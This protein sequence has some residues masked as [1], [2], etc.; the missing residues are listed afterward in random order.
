MEIRNPVFWAVII[1]WVMT[2]V[3][4]EFAHGLVAYL[5]GDYTIR[6]RGGLSLNPLQYVDPVFSLLLPTLFL[7]LGGVPLPGGST[8]IR[9]DLL[10]NRLWS[11]AVSLAGPFMNLLIFLA[12][13]LPFH[14]RIGWI[15]PSARGPWDNGQVLLG[16]MAILQLLA[17]LYNLVPVPPLDGFQAISPYLDPKTRLNLSTPPVSTILFLLFFLVLWKV[18]NLVADVFRYVVKPLLEHLGFQHREINFFR[19]AYNIALFSQSD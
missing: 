17:I 5:G 11:T 18:P 19:R 2:V 8:F 7:L 10:R 14:P 6:E 16:A 12:C 3:L 4:H 9:R 15:H 13:V 1:A